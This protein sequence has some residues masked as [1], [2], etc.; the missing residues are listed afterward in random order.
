MVVDEKGMTSLAGV[1]AVG[2]L[3]PG[4]GPVI[5]TVTDG[6]RAVQAIDDYL[7]QLPPAPTADR[8]TKEIGRAHV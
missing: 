2:D 4:A 7:R 1:F 8:Q 6:K 5:P 3:V